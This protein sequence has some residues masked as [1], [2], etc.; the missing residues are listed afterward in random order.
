[1]LLSFVCSP[2]RHNT[3]NQD[4]TEK[5]SCRYAL[6][7]YDFFLIFNNFLFANIECMQEPTRSFTTATLSVQL[8]YWIFLN[9]KYISKLIN[10][11][12]SKN[13]HKFDPYFRHFRHYA[14]FKHLST[15]FMR[16]SILYF[17]C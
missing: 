11:F 17:R 3:R 12:H 7:N 6:K 15:K 4:I 16:S 5:N 8:S 10:I 2:L 14:S 9:Y 1:M 13:K